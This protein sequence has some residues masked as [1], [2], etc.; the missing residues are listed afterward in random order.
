MRN[1]LVPY[2]RDLIQVRRDDLRS[3]ATGALEMLAKRLEGGADVGDE[4]DDIEQVAAPVEPG[5]D[6]EGIEEIERD[7]IQR[8]LDWLGSIDELVKII[9]KRPSHVQ[10]AHAPLEH[11]WKVI[12]AAVIIGTRGIENPLTKK[13]RKDETDQRAA[14]ARKN[15]KP[16]KHRDKIDTIVTDVVTACTNSSLRAGSA[17][18][19]A[20]ALHGKFSAKLKKK[21]RTK[22]TVAWFR[23]R[24][25]KLGLAGRKRRR[26]PSSPSS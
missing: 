6:Q 13:F 1:G 9:D 25:T 24:I 19:I 22:R 26:R 20:E 21:L 16:T 15:R 7:N 23:K 2:Y 4:L 3:I 14:H 11:L 12:G 17:T 8:A 18:G 10:Q 5:N